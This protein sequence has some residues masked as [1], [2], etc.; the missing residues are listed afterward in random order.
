MGWVRLVLV[1]AEQ[2]GHMIG[3]VDERE[4]ELE[5]ACV[6]VHVC[7]R[8][9]VRARAHVARPGKEGGGGGRTPCAFRSVT[10]PGS[11]CLEISIW[12]PGTGQGVCFGRI[13]TSPC[14]ILPK[15][16]VGSPFPSAPRN[17][18]WLY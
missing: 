7:V 15:E 10:L 9:H 16:E 4:S 2:G 14:A 17:S 18:T 13:E 1:W 5:R 12:R 8:V 3:P 11:K 6:C